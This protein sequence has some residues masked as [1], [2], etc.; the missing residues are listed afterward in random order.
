MKVIANIDFDAVKGLEG[1]VY[2]KPIYFFNKREVQLLLGF[3][4]LYRDPENFL[5]EYYK[6]IVTEDKFKYIY[7]GVKPAYHT[8]SDCDR[9]LS[10]FKNFEIPLLIRENGEQAVI[11][12][13]EWF[14]TVQKVFNET[15]M[16]FEALLF[17]RYGIQ[18]N[19]GEVDYK[20][21]GA[22]E[23]ENL[24]LPELEKRIDSLLNE[25]GSFFRNS[26]SVHQNIIRKLGKLTFLAYSYKKIYS[27][28]SGMSDEALKGFLGSY[29]IKF[30]K[31]IKVLLR[32]YY[33]VLYNPEMKFEGK[34]LEAL[35]F[36]P[37]G[38][39][40]GQYSSLPVENS[41]NQAPDPLW[42]LGNVAF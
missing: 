10:N 23:K 41:E 38:S 33:R 37:C 15:P 27:N 18:S 39:C 14:K 1:N 16:I 19:I 28:D 7:E 32:E 4:E 30:K 40:H 21:S 29:D 11:E 20:N 34:L 2:K 12:F 25:A 26:D 17:S 3:K 35:G 6:P 36:R 8:G 22:E 42:A 9:L 5:K 31:P 24:D 13:R